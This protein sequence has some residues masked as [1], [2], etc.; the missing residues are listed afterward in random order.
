[1]RLRPIWRRPRPIRGR[2][3][4]DRRKRRRYSRRRLMR[5]KMMDGK[6]ETKD[7]A[8]EKEVETE[9]EEHPNPY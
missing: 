9:A 1:M 4:Y 8:A 3:R 2:R 5:R 7:A 6:R